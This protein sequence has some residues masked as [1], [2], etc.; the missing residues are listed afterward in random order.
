MDKELTSYIVDNIEQTRKYR[1]LC[2]D[3]VYRTA[4][5]AAEHYQDRKSALKAAKRKL[6]QTYGAYFGEFKYDKI[7]LMIQ[8][9]DRDSKDEYLK[10]SCLEILQHH[11]STAERIPILSTFYDDIF[12]ETGSPESILD[13]ACGLNPFTLPW[14]PNSV[15]A[16]YTGVDI[17]CRIVAIINSF[18]A[19]YNSS[20]TAICRDILNMTCIPRADVVFILKTLPCL[21]QQQRGISSRLLNDL[22]TSCCV[23]SFPAR[24]LGGKDKGMVEHYDRF[25]SRITDNTGFS[26]TKL[27]YPS[28]TFYILRK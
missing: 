7:D 4:E 27:H 21:E 3:A 2:E 28:E 25:I 13:L 18:F 23:V 12:R 24:S 14:L 10:K 19:R 20:H 26:V 22:N 16:C 1:H 5:W 6:H 9:I 8:K 15:K 17:D 11:A